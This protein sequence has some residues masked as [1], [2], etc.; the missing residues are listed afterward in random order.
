MIAGSL[1]HCMAWD[2]G[3]P[4]WLPEKFL[5]RINT[6]YRI[7]EGDESHAEA[8]RKGRVGGGGGGRKSRKWERRDAFMNGV[9]G[10]FLV[11][12]GRGEAPLSFFLGMEGAG[13]KVES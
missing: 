5:D 12:K 3:R 4:R 1:S 13:R 11:A 8:R 6:I 10:S 2:K 7:G 9:N